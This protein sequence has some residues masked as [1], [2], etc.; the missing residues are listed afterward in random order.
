MGGLNN[1]GLAPPSGEFA[2]GAPGA[3][4]NIR[5]GEPGEGAIWLRKLLLSGGALNALLEAAEDTAGGTAV[6]RFKSPN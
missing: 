5:L 3:M 1:E 2:T 6:P 4:P